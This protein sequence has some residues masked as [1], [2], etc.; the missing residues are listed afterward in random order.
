MIAC[1]PALIVGGRPETARRRAL[2]LDALEESVERQV[3]I[4]PRLLAVGDDVE[5]GGELIVERAHHRVV[6]RFGD[7]GGAEAVEVRGRELQPAGKRI[8]ADDG[9]AQ[10]ALLH[11]V[12][13]SSLAGP[14]PAAAYSFASR[15]AC[16]S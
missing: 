15:R 5:P 10:G 13:V 7:V 12:V 11:G 3:E 2:Q 9:G 4:E 16:S 8:A 14:G 6:L 1:L